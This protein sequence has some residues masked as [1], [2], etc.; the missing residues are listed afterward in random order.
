MSKEL[1]IYCDES[2]QDGK[3]C[4]NFYGGV[5]VKSK[6]LREVE[7][8]L[9]H[10]KS[11]LNLNGEVKWSKITANYEDKYKSLL[12]TFF[13][14]VSEGKI[15]VRVMFTQNS[16]EIHHALTRQQREDTYYLLYYQFIKHA[17]GLYHYQ[18]NEPK[19][20]RI[21]FD[22][23]PENNEQ[24]DRFKAYIAAL[25]ATK[26]FKG[27]RLTIGPDDIYEVESHDHILLQCAD[28]V[29]GSM[30]FR[31]NHK[32]KEKPE[33]QARRGKRTLAKERVYKH[34][35]A[36]ICSCYPNFNIGV[37]T[38]MRGDRTN[39]WNHPYRHWLFVAKGSKHNP[40]RV[41]RKK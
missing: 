12:D 10:V 6:D 1:I 11:E 31:L 20:L 23:L 24:S 13:G 41:K 22:R 32:H 8:S 29:L 40:E 3:Y 2:E 4:S 15:K 33:G 7:E 34:I 21:N 26:D 19:R 28:I 16:N 37:S 17:F 14:L 27:S 25:S 18:P 5:L 30:S 36:H 9:L 38:S 39:T 35:N